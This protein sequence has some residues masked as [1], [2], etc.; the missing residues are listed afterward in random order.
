M[1]VIAAAINKES[2]AIACDTQSSNSWSKGSAQTKIFC[3]NDKILVGYT[4]TYLLDHWIQTE[5][6]K[7]LVGNTLR[8]AAFNAWDKWREFCRARGHG[9]I[10]E[11]SLNI[12]GQILI[13]NQE[14]IF[15]C[16]SDGSILQEENYAAIGSGMYVAL[17]SMFSSPIRHPE[18]LTR[19]AVRAAIKHTPFCGGEIKSIGINR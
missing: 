12:P 17:G 9:T 8:E 5:M 13:L 3:L 2:Y 16:N 15:S 14:G 11:G 7:L 1:T 10:E 4:G 18:E 6:S 19:E